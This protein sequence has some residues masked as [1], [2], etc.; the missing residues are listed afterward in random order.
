MRFQNALNLI[1]PFPIVPPQ[2]TPFEFGEETVNAQEMVLV[3]CTV[4]KGDLPLKI[5][6]YFNGNKVKSGD[7][8]VSLLNTKRT[9]QLSIES[10][11]HQNQGNYTCVVNNEAGSMNHTSQLFVNGITSALLTIFFVLYI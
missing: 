2:I 11:S 6:W 1:L 5:D 3:T 7:K 4:S 8:G 10:V 9:S